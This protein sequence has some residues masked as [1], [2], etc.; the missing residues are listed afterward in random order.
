MVLKESAI[1]TKPS[2]NS[3]DTGERVSHIF[4]GLSSLPQSTTKD[5]LMVMM[6]TIKHFSYYLKEPGKFKFMQNFFIIKNNL[7]MKKNMLGE[8]KNNKIQTDS[9]FN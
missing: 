3:K 7:K 5:L 8:W 4:C 2:Q 6:A 9:I 1:T